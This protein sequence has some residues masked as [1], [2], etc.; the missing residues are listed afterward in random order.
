VTG[1]QQPENYCYRSENCPCPYLCRQ[2]FEMAGTWP[3]CQLESR[4]T[5]VLDP[6]RTTCT[7]VGDAGAPDAGM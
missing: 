1:L 5:Y 4:E 3:V 6:Y 7:E 2:P